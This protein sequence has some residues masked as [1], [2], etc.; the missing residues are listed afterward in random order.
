M[1]PPSD[2]GL[3][4]ARA[5]L[6]HQTKGFLRATAVSPPCRQELRLTP[7]NWGFPRAC[8][9]LAREL[10]EGSSTHQTEGPSTAGTVPPGQSSPRHGHVRGSRRAGTLCPQSEQGPRR[11][12]LCLLHQTAR[13]LREAPQSFPRLRSLFSRGGKARGGVSGPRR[14]QVGPPRPGGSLSGRVCKLTLHRQPFVGRVRAGSA[15]PA[16]C[17]ITQYLG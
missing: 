9:F 13:S 16:K 10:P 7:Q 17:I 14:R 1:S 15:V 6:S 11:Q 5:C 4:E 3:P 8:A 2:Q 12:E